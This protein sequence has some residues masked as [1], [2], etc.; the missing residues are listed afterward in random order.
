MNVKTL[1]A[2]PVTR[3]DLPVGAQVRAALAAGADLIELRVDCLDEPG[4]VARLLEQPHDVPF[5]LTIRSAAEGGGWDG[6]E[7]E[8]VA[9]FES[10]GLKLPG[11]V[12]IEHAAW[13]RSANLR[14]K[15]G[16]VSSPGADGG[17]PRNRLILSY[18]DWRATPD[19]LYA[20]V[21]PLLE[22]P[23]DVVKVVFT[24]HS[25][26][27][28]WR[29][30]GLL[31][32]HG[33]SRPLI[34]LAMGA[35]GLLTRVLAP[36]FGAFLTFAALDAEST[37]APG[38]PTLAELLDVYRWRAI[39]PDTPVYGVVGWPVGQSKGPRVHNAALAAADM[40]GVYL[41]MPVP[42]DYASFAEFMELL[43]AQPEFGV[44]GLSVTMPHKEHAL[45]WLAEKGHAVGAGA[46]RV[47]AVNTLLRTGAA[48]W[49][50]EN[51][52]TVGLL[53]A[54]RTVPGLLDDP[55]CRPHVAVL[56]AGGVARAA[57]AALC[58]A[59]CRVTVFN[60]TEAR[61]AELAQAFGCA[62]RPWAERGGADVQVVVN[63]TSVGMAPQVDETPLSA[64]ALRPGLVV[65]D[66][67]Y[68]P[69]ETRL[70]REAAAR[71][72]R[73]VSGVQMLLSQ[74]AAQF[75]L[76][77]GGNAPLDAMRAAL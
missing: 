19:D 8:R 22:S 76:W 47:G 70:A 42:P 25:A 14:Q 51:T 48:G 29:V 63:C 71:G 54:L 27:D 5:I 52:D 67:V 16:L 44:R 41:P 11:Y 36:K 61:A 38:Q 50:G 58:D 57:V 74:A 72:A 34:A 40:A 53:A 37:A 24:A 75:E 13:V 33:G 6:D 1:L 28:A 60:R 31:R 10:L 21:R 49:S 56:G 45:R 77:H 9:L 55:G 32:R 15:L 2:V 65:L 20:V 26:A 30:L 46:Q 17:R 68:Q 3:C 18:H 59:G 35:A 43:T 64:D 4:E 12:D 62:A 23:A 39:E 69:A 66:T 73:V 7:S